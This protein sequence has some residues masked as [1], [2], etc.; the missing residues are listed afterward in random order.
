MNNTNSFHLVFSLLE[1]L[2]ASCRPPGSVW[3][4]RFWQNLESEKVL[5]GRSWQKAGP[6]TLDAL[7][8]RL[9]D[10]KGPACL[11]PWEAQKSHPRRPAC[12]GPA[13]C[14]FCKVLVAVETFRHRVRHRAG[15][16]GSGFRVQDLGF[17]LWG[18]ELRI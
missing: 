2:K 14:A 11:R 7:G 3:K 8:G 12:G 17:K 1:D 10:W 18:L 4:A 15:G 9:W 13:F 6:G 16:A 5:E